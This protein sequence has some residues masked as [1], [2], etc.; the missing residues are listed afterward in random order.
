VKAV[1]TALIVALLVLFVCSAVFASLKWSKTF[2]DL[3]KPK[4]DS[5]IVKA[6]CSICHVD[7]KGKG[8]LNP[9]GAMLK[10]KKVDPATLKA[11]EKKDADKDGVSN[12]A[13]IKAGTLPGDPKSKPGKK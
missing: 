3:Y 4:P 9:Y 1:R 2:K 8:K 10:G 5:A 7:P 12:I 11:I 13:E 6:K